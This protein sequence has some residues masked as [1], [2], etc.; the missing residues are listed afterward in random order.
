MREDIVD[1]GVLS[2]LFDYWDGRRGQRALPMRADI[3]PVDMPKFI[4]PHLILY[5]V[6]GQGQRFRYRLCGTEVASR[7]G[8]NPTGQFVDTATGATYGDYLQSLF[9]E[10]CREKMAVYSESTFIWRSGCD[11]TVRHL[12]LPLADMQGAID[13]IL[14]G[15]D[16]IGSSDRARKGFQPLMTVESIREI[17]RQRHRPPG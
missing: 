10:M 12:G 14:S 2:A 16:V 6:I 9:D 13:K 5:D 8:K 1:S 11:L 4:L 17:R 15:V 3:D 7:F